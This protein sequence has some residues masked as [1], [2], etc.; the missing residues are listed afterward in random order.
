MDSIRNAIRILTGFDFEFSKI[1]AWILLGFILI[2]RF[3]IDFIRILLGK[4]DDGQACWKRSSRLRG[5][6]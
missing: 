4:T 5:M 2:A 1:L 6:P 3:C